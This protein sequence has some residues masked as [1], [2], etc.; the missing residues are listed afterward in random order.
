YLR[1]DNLDLTVSG[2]SNYSNK[3]TQ[4]PLKKFKKDSDNKHNIL[5][6]HGSMAIPDKH[7]V[8]D[9]PFTM[10]QMEVA[11]VDYIALGHWHSYFDASKGKVITAYPGAPEAIDFDQ[12]G[13][14]H[15]IY[16]EINK[17]K[18]KIQKIKVGARSFAKIEVDLTAKEEINDFLEQ[19]IV[20]RQDPNLAL[21]VVV[22]GYL[23][24]QSII[25]KQELLDNLS[26]DFYLLKIIDKTHLALDKISL[27]EFPEELVVGQYVRALLEKIEQADKKEEKE[28]YEK[29]LQVGVAMLEGKR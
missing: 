20:K 17:D 27:E 9:F 8:D 5:M 7:A 14:G 10:A 23:G 13:A 18:V 25:R 19:E 21:E 12:K 1:F 3:S 24:P 15:V 6:I 22:K 29:A 28:I 16:G 26:E 11:E 2:V 4:S